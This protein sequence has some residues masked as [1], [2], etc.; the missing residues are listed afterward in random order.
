LW[1]RPGL[2]FLGALVGFL[3]AHAL[4]DHLDAQRALLGARSPAPA[5]LRHHPLPHANASPIAAPLARLA[6]RPAAVAAGGA[7]G[8]LVALSFDDGPGPYTPAIVQAL[9]RLHAPAT[10]FVLGF[11]LHW[12]PA[13]LRA[14][15]R[16]GDALEIHT[17]DHRDLR[18][19]SGA[20]VRRELR[21]TA[22]ALRLIAGVRS[23]LVR[24][25]YG[26]LDRRVLRRIRAAHMLGVLWSVDTGDWRRPGTRTI[27]RR[28]LAGARP[29]AIILLH[30]GGGQR[31]QTLAAIPAIVRG[32]RARGLR[33]VTVPRLLALAPPPARAL[34]WG[35]SLEGD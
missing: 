33:L 22:R 24:P 29:G 11:E 10:F 5:A 15:A 2:A 23:S 32:L 1:V 3:A 34:N 26:A 12:Y 25:P 35:R 20:Q 14:M 28:A 17:W 18:R 9:R 4:R 31:G 19:L 27:V 16:D 30:D 13:T 7:R 21:S 6:R 8:R